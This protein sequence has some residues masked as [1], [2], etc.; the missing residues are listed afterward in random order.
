M[1]YLL[2]L[3]TYLEISGRILTV[4][5]VFLIREAGLLLI[6]TFVL[7]GLSIAAAYEYQMEAETIS[8]SSTAHQQ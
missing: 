3:L 2:L 6:V 7:M 8:L 4:F 1:P 5:V